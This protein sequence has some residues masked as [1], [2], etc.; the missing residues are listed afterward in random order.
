MSRR[1]HA[2]YLEHARVVQ[3]AGCVQYACAEDDVRKHNIPDR[4]T[5]LLFL[6]KGT[7]I[8]EAAMRLLNE[9]DVVVGFCGADGLPLHAMSEPAWLQPQGRYR[10]T[11]YCQSWVTRWMD[12]GQRLEMGRRLLLARLTPASEGGVRE[13]L[14]ASV[15]NAENVMEMIAAEGRYTKAVY[16]QLAEQYD[17]EFKREAGER[18]AGGEVNSLLDYGNFFAYGF[19]TVALNVLGIPPAFPVLHGLTRHGGL[20]FDVADLIKER[21]VMPLAFD[22]GAPKSAQK[23]RK[24]MEGRGLSANQRAFRD[25]VL[26]GMHK[27]DAIAVM[28]DVL[29]ALLDGMQRDFPQKWCADAEKHGKSFEVTDE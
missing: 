22:Y 28:I 14:E 23:H 29:K 27:Q 11:T 19:A 21:M 20:V 6:G 7:S 18:G 17:I 3:E 13:A 2:F 25:A 1:A 26:Q 5:A 4:N 12:E 10:P 15:R 16:R 8:T 24:R 9:S